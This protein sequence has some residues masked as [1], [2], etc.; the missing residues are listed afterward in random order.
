MVPGEESEPDDD[1]DPRRPQQADGE[2]AAEEGI[3]A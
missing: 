2:D 1:E 3:E